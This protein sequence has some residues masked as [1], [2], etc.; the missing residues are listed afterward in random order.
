MIPKK[1]MQQYGI[2]L[3]VLTLG[4]PK[5]A[6]AVHEAV[7]TAQSMGLDYADWTWRIAEEPNERTYEKWIAAAKIIR[8]ADPKVRIWCNPGEIQGSTPK[9]V[10]AMSPWIDV[11]CPYVNQFTRAPDAAYKK[12]VTNLGSPK[13]LYTTPCFREK[14]PGAPLELLALAKMA[15]DNG[16]DGWDCFTLCGFYSAT[17]G[18]WDEVNAPYGAQAVSIYPGAGRRVIGSRNLEAVR[19]AIQIWKAA[20]SAKP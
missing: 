15:L 10:T 7:E 5:S 6:Q 3:I 11:F 20:K 17:A 13:L 2:R 8:Q 19:Q 14:S 4:T 18:A 1:Q 16:R 9:A 12:L